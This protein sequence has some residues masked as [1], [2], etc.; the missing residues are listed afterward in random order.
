MNHRGYWHIHLTWEILIYKAVSPLSL[1]S[2]CTKLLVVCSS[3]DWFCSEVLKVVGKNWK[4]NWKIRV[5]FWI[6]PRQKKTVLFLWVVYVWVKHVLLIVTP[7][8]FEN[9]VRSFAEP[10]WDWLF[11]TRTVRATEFIC[12]IL[13]Y[14]LYLFYVQFIVRVGSCR[15]CKLAE[16]FGK[17]NILI[18]KSKS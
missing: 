4:L 18:R 12:Y 14:L 8:Q 15:Q 6:V 16:V 9:S 7:R 2:S 3:A 13:L 11:Q 17:A 1:F 10:G 5:I